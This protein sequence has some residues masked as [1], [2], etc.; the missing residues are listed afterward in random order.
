[1]IWARLVRAIALVGWLALFTAAA[2]AVRG[3]ARSVT[4]TGFATRTVHHRRVRPTAADPPDGGL[5]TGPGLQKISG[6]PPREPAADRQLPAVTGIA[7]GEGPFGPYAPRN[8]PKGSKRPHCGS[9]ETP[10]GE[11][12]L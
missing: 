9:P 4:R 10:A 12:V 2:R 11:E 8:H 3:T 1:M 7:S 5:V 6:L